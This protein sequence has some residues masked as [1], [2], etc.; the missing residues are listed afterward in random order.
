[1]FEVGAEMKI[2]IMAGLPAEWY[3]EINAAQRFSLKLQ[4][5]H[6]MSCKNFF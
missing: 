2:T 5:Y 6:S 1:M 3:V 4:R